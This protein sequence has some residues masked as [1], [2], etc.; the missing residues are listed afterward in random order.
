M[1]NL[2]F[3]EMCWKSHFV[4]DLDDVDFLHQKSSELMKKSATAVPF[5]YVQSTKRM[6]RRVKL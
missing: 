1:P 3:P 6:P 2:A 4:C 5:E